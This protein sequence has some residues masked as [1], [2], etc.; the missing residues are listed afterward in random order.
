M[1]KSTTSVLNLDNLKLNI[2]TETA[3]TVL[4]EYMK[5]AQLDLIKKAH[6]YKITP[7]KKEGGTLADLCQ[8]PFPSIRA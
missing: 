8:R 1:S 3:E 2:P 4:V 7:P 6:P 5:K